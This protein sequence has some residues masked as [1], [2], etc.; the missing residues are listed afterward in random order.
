MN[1]TLP[2]SQWLSAPRSDETVIAWLGDR[3]WTLGQLRYDVAALLAPLREQEGQRWA[4][5][6]ENSYLFIVALLATLH[7]G[8]TPVIPGHCRPSLLDEQRALFDGVLSESPLDWRGPHL[9]VHSADDG[10]TC[11]AALPPIPADALVTLFT[12]G[13]TGQPKRVVKRIAA[14]DAEAALLGA[15]F[16]ERLAG[17]RVVASVVPQHLY[18]LTFRIFLPMA[19]GLPLHA[20]MTHYAEQLAAL[21]PRH[22]YLFVSSPAFLKRLDHQL[23]PPPL[24]MLLSAGGMLPWCDVT[25]SQRWLGIWPDEIYGSTETGILAWRHR[26]RD[27]VPWLPFPGVHITPE[28]DAFRVRSPLIADPDGLLLDDVLRFG[29]DGR[30]CLAGRRGRVVKIEEKRI[31]LSEIER[32]LTDIDGIREAAAIP[33]TRGGRQ[34]IGVLLVLDD[35][36]RQRWQETHGKALA[37]SWRRA[38]LPWLEPVAIPRYWRVLDEIP[39]NS[40]NKRV[41][42]QLQELFDETS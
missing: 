23:A 26:Q 29:D 31:S 1:Q 17:C 13:S 35:A 9:Q 21:N 42:A 19:L 24:A 18:G 34:G 25:R 15:R 22:R 28:G 14:L 32:R 10:R 12:S 7:A 40:M 27:S 20:A 2:L 39:V 8:K 36:L 5:C 11:A 41:Y 33:I 3:S 38:L 6:F 16:A 30:F 4:L 37:L